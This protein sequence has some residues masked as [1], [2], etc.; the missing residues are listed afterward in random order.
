MEYMQRYC[1]R[2]PGWIGLFDALTASEALKRARDLVESTGG[3]RAAVRPDMVLNATRDDIDWFNQ[4]GDPIVVEHGAI[5]ATK[6]TIDARVEAIAMRLE[7]AVEF[8][9]VDL[10]PRH[11]GVVRRPGRGDM[12]I[13][14]T[15][16]G[17]VTAGFLNV[18]EAR[19]G[20]PDRIINLE[21]GVE[22]Q[23]VLQVAIGRELP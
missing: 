13:L 14:A 8:N 5:A 16:R 4:L 7:G 19:D 3:D 6:L 18:L 22:R 1:V 10:H 20:Y 2:I 15:A 9:R 17:D 11:A 23:V 12:L 21:T